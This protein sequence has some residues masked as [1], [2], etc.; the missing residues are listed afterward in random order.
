MVVVDLRGQDIGAVVTNLRAAARTVDLLWNEALGEGSGP[1]ALPLA[2]AS[3]AIHRALIALT[4]VDIADR[5]Q[6]L[7]LRR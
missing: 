4:A 2:Q 3:Q 5:P 6:A 1:A 7:A